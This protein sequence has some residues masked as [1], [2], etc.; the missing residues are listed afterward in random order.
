M[1]FP[2]PTCGAAVP[3]P[4]TTEEPLRNLQAEPRTLA[5]YQKLLASNVAP[6]DAELTAIRLIETKASERLAYLDD[7]IAQVRGLLKELEEERTAVLS[8]HAQNSGILSP[9]R[10]MP[11]EIL[12]EIFSWTL[13]SI[14][15]ALER[16][17]D[18]RSSPWVLGQTSSFWRAVALSTP[19][20]WSLIAIDYSAS[21]WCP[22]PMLETQIARARN[23][24]VTI[25]GCKDAD[26]LSQVAM[27]Q[28]LAERSSLWE[29][30]SV[31]LISDMVPIIATL[32]NRLPLLRRLWISWNDSE[33][34]TAVDLS[35]AFHTA[36]SLLEAGFHNGYHLA[37]APFPVHQLTWYQLNATWTI[38]AGIL[39]LAQNLVE[40]RLAIFGD[41]PWPEDGDIIELPRLRRLYVSH[42]SILDYLRTPALQ[43][44][45]FRTREAD[46]DLL[47]PTLDSFLIRSACALRRVCFR[48]YPD[49]RTV[50][51]ILKQFPAI[52]QLAILTWNRDGD[53][54]NHCTAAN[55]L[56]SSLTVSN[57]PGSAA[58]SPQ[59]TTIEF[60]CEEETYIDHALYLKML[61]SR[62]RAQSCAL[63]SASLF[64]DSGPGP[65]PTTLDG[66]HSLR[67]EGLDLSLQQGREAADVM[68]H[69]IYIPG[70]A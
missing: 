3:R 68:G 32:R 69:W 63:K 27:F 34:L 30:L 18:V 70:W 48:G 23:L 17:F 2:C 24:K 42:G 54:D 37:T 33:N 59:L 20:L 5:L 9:L 60:G 29:E 6:E 66:L 64:M 19:S 47:L 11:P 38:H 8:L 28:S 55:A 67:N 4:S 1:T 56:I 45:A 7:R 57:P 53:L 62:W 36:P 16:G 31:G 52:T 22:L 43:E 26:S 46:Q 50:I 51:D 13:P 40:A 61:E 14:T 12:A 10:R 65:N 44:I 21:I 25:Y 39:K 35:D 41:E 15:E 49:A 58:V